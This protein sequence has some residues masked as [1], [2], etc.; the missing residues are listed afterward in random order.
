L[1]PAGHPA[2]IAGTVCGFAGG[3]RPDDAPGFVVEGGPVGLRRREPGIP[4]RSDA[5]P[6]GAWRTGVPRIVQGS[7]EMT[8]VAVLGGSGYTALELFRLL[9]RHPAARIEAVT[10][11]DQEQPK[12]SSLHP[13][14]AGRLDLTCEPFD[15]ER[16]V[17]RVDLAF[18]CLPH[19]A[20]MDSVRPLLERG[21]RVVDLSADYRLNDPAVYETWYKHRHTDVTNLAGAVYGLP[22]LHGAKI[23]PAR[24]I[25]NPGCYTSASILG[26]VPLVKEGLIEPANIIIDAKS[27]VSGAGRTPKLPYHYPECNES[28]SP[29]GVGNHR[30]TPEIEQ[31][32]TGVAGRPIEVLFTPHL[33]PMDRGILATIYTRPVRPVTQAELMTLYRD[34]YRGKP[35]VRVVD[36]LP[37]TKQTSHTNF[38]DLTVRVVKDRVLVFSA[39]DN[40]IKGAA[41]VA[42]QNFNLL[43]DRPETDGLH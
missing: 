27:G 38:C 2:G 21:I 33:V 10:S 8:R 11:R 22:E 25:A 29:Y 39:L 37:T 28:L 7:N 40:L 31:E 9:L 35:F 15:P 24:L 20:A 1:T 32:L 18:V 30:H 5:L 16:L 36:D 13:S 14:L 41:G 3:F 4:N 43:T 23:P 6:F 12:V 34:F 19:A 42:V 26:L 17:G